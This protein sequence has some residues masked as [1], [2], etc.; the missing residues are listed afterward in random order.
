M[1]NINWQNMN[2]MT[3]TEQTPIHQWNLV[4]GYGVIDNSTD[5]SRF[6]N[7]YLYNQVL[8][9]MTDSE[10]SIIKG[11]YGNDSS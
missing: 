8:G 4:G 10:I 7:T 11:I 5:P 3:T 2:K 1:Y 6:Q 9:D